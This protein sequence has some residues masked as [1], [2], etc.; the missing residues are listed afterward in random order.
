MSDAPLLRY[1]T[2]TAPLQA[3]TPD[4]PGANAID[5]TVSSPAGQNV[6]CDKLDVA[7]PV[8]APD[9]GGAYFTENPRSSIS[10]KWSIASAQVKTGRELGLAPATN[11]YHVVFQAPPIPGFDL[12]DTPLTISISGDLAATPGSILTCPATETS[13]TTSG[14]YARKTPQ[15]LTWDTAEPAFYLHN[16]LSGAPDK[17]TVPRTKF[18]T[19]AE[20]LLTWESNGSEFQLYDG[21]GTTLYEGTATSCTL[22]GSTIV[23]D[24]TLTLRASVTTGFET[25]Y[26]CATLTVTITDPTLDDLKVANKLT[27]VGSNGLIVNGDLTARSALDVSGST[28]ARGDLYARS[29]LQ[30]DHDATVFGKANLS[31]LFEE[32]VR[33]EP[34]FSGGGTDYVHVDHDGILVVENT[35]QGSYGSSEPYIFV[36]REEWS[37]GSTIAVNIK[38]SP[39][40]YTIPVRK[41]EKWWLANLNSDAADGFRFYWVGFC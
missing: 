29:N 19:G 23:N 33:L 28:T 36:M 31:A 3:G 7:V 37:Q 2:S 41:G 24:T 6:Y 1:S 26:R 21:F 25:S 10:G 4:K 18:R 13:G 8:S 35:Y 32:A 22:A 15:D 27:T 39:S 40:C 38:G 30:V 9:D 16:F 14:K 17:P 11:Y 20:I 12:I 34:E 5:I